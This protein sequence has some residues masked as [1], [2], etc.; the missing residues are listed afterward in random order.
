VKGRNNMLILKE[1]T[2]C[3]KK[4]TCEAAKIKCTVGCVEIISEEE[5]AKRELWEGVK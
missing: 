2:N 1:C 3:T 4:A 5:E